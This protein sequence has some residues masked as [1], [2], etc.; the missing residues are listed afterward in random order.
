LFDRPW[1]IN[2]NEIGSGV[3]IVFARFIDHAKQIVSLCEVVLHNL[4]ELSQL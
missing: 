1:E 4:I 3:Q 2:A